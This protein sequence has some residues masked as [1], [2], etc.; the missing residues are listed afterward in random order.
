MR[1]QLPPPSDD[2]D[3]DDEQSRV[4]TADVGVVE[5]V[6]FGAPMAS[7]EK[8]TKRTHTPNRKKT[9]RRQVSVPLSNKFSRLS[10]ALSRRRLWGG[11]AQTT[12]VRRAL[13]L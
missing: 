5:P 10:Q 4:L 8:Q 12:A 11:R 9:A 13:G 2:G 1:F 3:E 6:L 7:N